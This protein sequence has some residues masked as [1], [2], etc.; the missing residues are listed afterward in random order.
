MKVY[1]FLVGEDIRTEVGNKHS[2]MGLFGDSL[3]FTVPAEA[4]ASPIALRL[5]F[6]L[7]LEFGP[8]DP[9]S[10]SFQFKIFSQDKEVAG[11][12]GS[13]AKQPGSGGL[14]VLPLVANLLQMPVVLGTNEVRFRLT[15][16]DAATTKEAFS[17]FLR[18]ITFVVNKA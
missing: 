7:R 2:L 17:D 6:F 5:A 12:E 9:D 14:V 18:P 3:T 11:F 16:K 13:A 1:D 15:V 8:T 10:F 4:V